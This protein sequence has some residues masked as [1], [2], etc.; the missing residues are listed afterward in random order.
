[1]QTV[2]AVQVRSDVDVA[3]TLSYCDDEQTVNAEHARFVDV[4][5]AVL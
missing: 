5:G 3:A 1:M 4:V 2:N